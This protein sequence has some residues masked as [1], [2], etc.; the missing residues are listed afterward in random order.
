MEG[1]HQS[2]HE[3]AYGCVN[4]T[5]LNSSHLFLWLSTSKPIF[6]P[7]TRLNLP[8]TPLFSLLCTPHHAICGAIHQAIDVWSVGCIFAELIG[9]KPL[10]PGRDYVQQIN[11]I[12]SILGTPTEEDTKYIESD[13]AKRYIQ[14]LPP[15]PKISFSQIYP[16]SSDQAI[17]LLE[18]MLVFDPTKRISVK[19]VCTCI[20]CVCFL[21][22]SLFLP[23]P[24]S[25]SVCVSRKPLVD[26]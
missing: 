14:S 16:E 18:K 11:L 23:F 13:R 8:I 24:L 12:C 4:Q 25:L 20:A 21:V 17:D 1:I 2:K 7:D 5:P 10:F 6:I 15:R 22:L 26:A 3:C 9:R 19:E